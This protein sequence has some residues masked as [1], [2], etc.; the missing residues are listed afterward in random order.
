[1]CSLI[2]TNLTASTKADETEEEQIADNAHTIIT[3]IYYYVVQSH[4]DSSGGD[5]DDFF[6][7][8][9]FIDVMLCDD[10]DCVFMFFFFFAI[11]V[12]VHPWASVVYGND[13]FDSETWIL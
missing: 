12:S 13:R 1:M 7:L 3:I 5:D 10:D 6:V 9:L 4:D 2:E 8:L 11:H